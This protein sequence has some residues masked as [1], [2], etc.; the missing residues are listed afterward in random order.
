MERGVLQD[1][2]S[3]MLSAFFRKL[4]EIQKEKKER[5]KEEQAQVE[6]NK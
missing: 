3:E 6:K 4:R 1:E 5:K 2:C